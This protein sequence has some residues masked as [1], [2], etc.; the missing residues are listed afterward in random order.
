MKLKNTLIIAAAIL[1]VSSVAIGGGYVV[2]NYFF[3]NATTTTLKGA[4]SRYVRVGEGGVTAHNLD[5][6]NDLLVTGDLEVLGTVYMTGLPG[7]VEW[8]GPTTGGPY[9][10]NDAATYAGASALCVAIYQGSHVCGD[11]EIGQLLD[12]GDTFIDPATQLPCVQLLWFNA[13]HTGYP[14]VL[15]NDCGGWGTAAGA[16]GNYWDF[17]QGKPLMSPCDVTGAFR[18]EFAC[19]STSGQGGGGQPQ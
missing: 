5:S 19:C 18:H 4:P 6:P 16:Y 12:A 8:A 17:A 11:A 3:V 1:L 13:H 14:L 15:S 2:A 7:A 10:G 9:D